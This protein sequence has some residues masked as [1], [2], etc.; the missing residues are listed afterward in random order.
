MLKA[1]SGSM[2]PV[3]KQRPAECYAK[4]LTRRAIDA[5]ERHLKQATFNLKPTAQAYLIQ[6]MTSE[7][8]GFLPYIRMPIR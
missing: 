3:R 8:L 6:R 7:N 4:A 5:S 1:L 2:K